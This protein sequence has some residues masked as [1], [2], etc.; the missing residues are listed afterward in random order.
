MR[1]KNPFPYHIQG[2][3]GGKWNR[4]RALSLSCT[5]GSG[6]EQKSEKRITFPIIYKGQWEMNGE[7]K[8]GNINL[9]KYKER[10]VGEEPKGN[11]AF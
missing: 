8:G 2:A 5:R 6:D 11:V 1:E 4:E 9:T 3:V 10:T 7:Q